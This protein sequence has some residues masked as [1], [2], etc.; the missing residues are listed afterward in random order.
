MAFHE[1]AGRS[2]VG[3]VGF[4]G[5]LFFSRPAAAVATLP[6]ALLMSDVFARYQ[7]GV[8]VSAGAAT[9]LATAF[10]LDHRS[11]PGDSRIHWNSALGLCRFLP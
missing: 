2:Q 5:H 11:G 9:W 8:L 3:S 10:D 7:L 4:G 6:P 1:K